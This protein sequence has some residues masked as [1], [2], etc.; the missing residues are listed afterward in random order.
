MKWFIRALFVVSLL[1]ALAVPVMAASDAQPVVPTW[2]E[3]WQWV[4]SAVFV[5]PLL[6]VLKKLPAPWGAWFD[7]TAWVLA[8]LLSGAAPLV[9]Q[10]VLARIPD[11]PMLLWTGVY[12]LALWGI[13]QLVYR[14]GRVSGRI[15]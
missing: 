8:A 13:N 1:L 12:C 11:V 15:S 3:F 6:E 5:V 9:S 4:A 14:I 10:W 2:P 7:R